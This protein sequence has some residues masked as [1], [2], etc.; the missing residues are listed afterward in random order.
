M[1]TIFASFR[2]LY[3]NIQTEDSIKG[4]RIY[5]DKTQVDML[6]DD[7]IPVVNIKFYP[8]DNIVEVRIYSCFGI[9]SNKPYKFNFNNSIA[10]SCSSVIRKNAFGY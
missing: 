1:S 8:D 9:C 7:K 6:D 3:N 2:S 5:K 10:L 4:Y